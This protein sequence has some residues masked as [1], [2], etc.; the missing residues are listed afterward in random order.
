MKVSEAFV[1]NIAEAVIPGSASHTIKQTP[2]GHRK[3][4][5]DDPIAPALIVEF[6]I[7][8]FWIDEIASIPLADE[9]PIPDPF[10][11]E[12][13]SMYEPQIKRPPIIAFPCVLASRPQ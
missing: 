1:N 6:Q 5:E 3:Q 8:M 9:V 7:A 10:S 2:G 11:C 13:A 12:L 4:M